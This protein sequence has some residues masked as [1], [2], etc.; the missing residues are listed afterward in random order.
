MLQPYLLGNQ[1]DHGFI[2]FTF[3]VKEKGRHSLPPFVAMGPE[4]DSQ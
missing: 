2:N 1:Y 3:E 4:L